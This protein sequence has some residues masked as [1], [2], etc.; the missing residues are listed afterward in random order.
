MSIEV[1]KPGMQSTIQ[2]L[3]RSGYQHYGVIKGGAMDRIAAQIANILVN[4]TENE[5][6]IEFCLM[7]PTLKF[8]QDAIIALS[9]ADFQP[10]LDQMPVRHLCPIYVY[11]GQTLKLKHAPKGCY[12]YLAIA[13]GFDIPEILGSQSTYIQAGF[14]GF[15]G[16]AL[17]TED[18]L[19]PRLQDP[20]TVYSKYQ[21]LKDAPHQL[22]P[23]ALGD[24]S[25]KPLLSPR[26]S[27]DVHTGQ[28]IHFIRVVPGA[29]YSWFLKADIERFHCIKYTIT[30]ASNRMGYR[31]SGET[32]VSPVSTSMISE[33]VSFGSIQIPENGQPI[34]LMADHQTSGGYP[35]L[36]QVIEAD[37]PRLG[38]LQ[39]KTLVR[40]KPV[41]IEYAH[42][43]KLQQKAQL[44]QLK[45]ALGYVTGAHH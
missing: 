23:R 17:K 30:Q 19:Y 11:A 2:D 4:N 26:I 35:K 32:D 31:L 5:G 37:L 1:Y 22:A 12:G 42:T 14:G 36:A 28:N 20:D 9:G 27:Y 34:V 38:Q 33:A 25:V 21:H 40:F 16:R 43:I 3:G 6:V 10:E 39:P 24:W 29:Q 7:G 44:N 13:G 18:K 8:H 45:T 15:K 41:T